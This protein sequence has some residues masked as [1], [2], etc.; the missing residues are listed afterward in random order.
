M[1]FPVPEARGTLLEALQP[2]YFCQTGA[3]FHQNSIVSGIIWSDPSR[4][5]AARWIEVRGIRSNEIDL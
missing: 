1:V 2:Q 4:R 5:K 3:E